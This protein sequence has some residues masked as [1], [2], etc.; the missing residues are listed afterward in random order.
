M[1]L[2]PATTREGSL[3]VVKVPMA[4]LWDLCLQTEQVQDAI[5]VALRHITQ[6][7]SEI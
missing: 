2:H 3:A 5:V 7:L 4:E 6:P 1:L